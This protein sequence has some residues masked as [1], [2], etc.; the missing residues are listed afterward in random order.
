MEIWAHRGASA[1]APENTMSAFRLAAEQGAD[2]IEFDVHRTA[3]GELVVI[4]DETIDRTSNGR[5]VVADL[6]LEQLRRYSY[7][8]SHGSVAHGLG[9]EH[10]PWNE[11]DRGDERE[12]IPTLEEVLEWLPADMQA[13][14]ELKTLPTFYPGIAARAADII[15]VSG[16][17]DRVWVS[18]FNH[19]TL[20][21]VRAQAPQLRLGVLTGAHLWRPADYVSSC[22]AAAYHPSAASLQTPE[23]VAEC[24]GAGLRVHVWTLDDPEHIRLAEALGVDAVITNAPGAA[25]AALRG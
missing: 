13:N 24:H 15:T 11:N 25:R 9:N 3:D 20:A 12:P 23:I 16:V 22:G 17:S 8:V 1:E 2:A 7:D 6:T 14:V 4:H 21:E 18:S 10:G 5:G 19:H